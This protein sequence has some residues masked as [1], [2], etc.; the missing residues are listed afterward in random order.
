MAIHRKT[1]FPF[2]STFKARTTLLSQGQI[3]CSPLAQFPES[4]NPFLIS[5]PQDNTSRFV[6]A[7]FSFEDV[8]VPKGFSSPRTM[9]TI[10]SVLFGFCSGCLHCSHPFFSEH[11]HRERF[12]IIKNDSFKLIPYHLNYSSHHEIGQRWTTRL[13]NERRA[14]SKS[15]FKKRRFSAEWTPQILWLFDC[16][17]IFSLQQS[18][19]VGESTSWSAGEKKRFPKWKIFEAQKPRTEMCERSKFVYFREFHSIKYSS[20]EICLNLRESFSEMSLSHSVPTKMADKIVFWTSCV[21]CAKSPIWR[22]KHPFKKNEMYFQI[23]FYFNA[24]K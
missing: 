3:V 4:A 9:A 11:F 5:K 7:A 20:P 18:N 15:K 22:R 1:F 19:F 8:N 16:E 13:D 23:T 14:K 21:F 17:Y 12:V 2:F 24:S 6:L 10:Y